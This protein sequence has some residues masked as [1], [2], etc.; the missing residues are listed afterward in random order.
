MTQLH[1]VDDYKNYTSGS[2][3]I[4]IKTLAQSLR[5]HFRPPMKYQEDIWECLIEWYKQSSNI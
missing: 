2:D 1:L 3:K 4:G 5:Q